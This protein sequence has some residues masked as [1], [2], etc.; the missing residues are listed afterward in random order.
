MAQPAR[1][2]AALPAAW[3][4]EGEWQ[5]A[6]PATSAVMVTTAAA[7]D[8]PARRRQLQRAVADMLGPEQRTPADQQQFEGEKLH[9]PAQGSIPAR[10]GQLSAYVPV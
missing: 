4:A 5:Q 2:A 9:G 1:W 10:A 6:L 7:P 8:I 3:P